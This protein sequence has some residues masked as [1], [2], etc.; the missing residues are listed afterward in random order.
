[1]ALIH[2]K[3]KTLTLAE[4]VSL[5]Q[6]SDKNSESKGKLALSQHSTFVSIF[7]FKQSSEDR[8]KLFF[9]F[10]GSTTCQRLWSSECEEFKGKL[11]E[12]F[13]TKYIQ[14]IYQLQV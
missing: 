7:N 13:F 12:F 2:G 6:D 3:Y 5:P 1:M 10:K 14:Q 11:Y 9:K 8:Q 4:K